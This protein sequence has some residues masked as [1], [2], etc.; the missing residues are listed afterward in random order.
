M[1]NGLTKLN[2]GV[3]DL[4]I[5]VFCNLPENQGNIVRVKAAIGM[6]E[7]VGATE[8][9]FTWECEIAT[10]HGWLA[11]DFDGYLETSKVGPVPDKYLRRLTPPE[12]CLTGELETS[13]PMQLVFPEFDLTSHI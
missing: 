1:S 7:W 8:P 10:E 4:A 6:D 13:H 9:L 2:C 12:D 3:G 11:Y 5:T